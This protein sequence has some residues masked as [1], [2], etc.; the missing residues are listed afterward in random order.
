MVRSQA[1]LT[2]CRVCRPLISVRNHYKLAQS[3]T[4]KVGPFGSL[5]HAFTIVVLLSGD[6]ISTDNPC[7]TIALISFRNP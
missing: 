6:N 2:N 3:V 7:L 5:I 1:V 4:I